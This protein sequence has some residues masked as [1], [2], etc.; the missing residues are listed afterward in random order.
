MKNSN[1]ETKTYKLSLF[2]LLRKKL[3]W[4]FVIASL[5]FCAF[6]IWFDRG[7]DLILIPLFFVFLVGGAILGLVFYSPWY[8]NFILNDWGK[9]LHIDKQRKEL[10]LKKGEE[11]KTLHFSEIDC[12]R[13][14][15]NGSC[16]NPWFYYRIRLKEPNDYVFFISR[17]TVENL[18]KELDTIPFYY[19]EECSV[20]IPNWKKPSKRT[21]IEKDRR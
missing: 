18:E 17:L 2:K 19:T 8:I 14:F 13:K 16:R 9:E 12:V 4:L 11:Q 21:V 6:A 1:I 5:L 10:F 3:L 15:D 20:F 7:A